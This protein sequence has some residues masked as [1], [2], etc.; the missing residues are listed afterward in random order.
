MAILVQKKV[1]YVGFS[2]PA[3]P[4]RG[5][6]KKGSACLQAFQAFFLCRMPLIE[7]TDQPTQRLRWR[8]GDCRL[9]FCIDQV[10]G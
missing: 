7:S 3:R 10:V 4:E 9:P 5:G 1:N 6:S 8:T 2:P